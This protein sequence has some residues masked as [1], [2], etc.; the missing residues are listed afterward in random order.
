[1]ALKNT[2]T[3]REGITVTDSYC[4][5]ENTTV[6]PARLQFLIRSYKDGSNNFP[7]FNEDA[8]NI[9]YDIDGDNP[10]KQAYLYLKTLPEFSNAEDI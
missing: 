3:T 8:F 6:S 2:V 5:V 1:M 4:R 9:V 7:F 10:I